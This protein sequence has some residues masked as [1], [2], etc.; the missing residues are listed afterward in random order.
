M[1]CVNL[2]LFAGLFVGWVEGFAP[3]QPVPRS[4]VTCFEKID[5]AFMWPVGMEYGKGQFKFYSGFDEWMKPFPDEDRDQYPEVFNLPTGLY[6]V[7]LKKPLGIIFEEIDA[8]KGLFV[9]ELVEDG[10]AQREGTV[11]PG[12]V[13]V[14]MTAVKPMGVKYERRMI[15]AR[16]FNFDLMVR[17]FILA[18]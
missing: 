4:S 12:D 11:K 16:N 9:Q 14:G 5:T 3:R 7:K 15:P 1:L 10:N 6:E 8:G 17:H 18:S 13:L 2:I